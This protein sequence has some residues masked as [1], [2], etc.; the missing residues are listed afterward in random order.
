M[1]YPTPLAHTCGASGAFGG[2]NAGRGGG[3]VIA[4]PLG[5]AGAATA[6]MASILALGFTCSKKNQFRASSGNVCIYWCTCMYIYTN[7]QM[8]YYIYTCIYIYIYIC[9]YTE[10]RY[11]S[12]D[13]RFKKTIKNI[14]SAKWVS[15]ARGQL[16]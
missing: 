12:H 10:T 8:L 9:T 5:T 15:S 1:P 7:L 16:E 6:W 3:A 2:K 14:R 13:G 11:A 4:G